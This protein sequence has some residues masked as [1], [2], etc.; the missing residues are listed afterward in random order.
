MEVLRKAAAKLVAAVV[1]VEAAAVTLDLPLVPMPAVVLTQSILS[2]M[3]VFWRSTQKNMEM[4]TGS[5]TM[6]SR[7]IFLT[8]DNISS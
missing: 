4:T 3:L 7:N 8:R 1:A 5:M 6:V 2:G